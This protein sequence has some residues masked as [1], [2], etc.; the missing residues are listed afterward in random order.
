MTALRG[1]ALFIAI[2]LIAGYRTIAQPLQGASTHAAAL[3]TLSA[4]LRGE[5]SSV[6]R[7]KC[8][9]PAIAEGRRRRAEL[10]EAAN[11]ALAVLNARPSL[12][13]SIVRG[14]F[15]IHFDLTGTN[16]P[17]LLDASGNAIP[18]TAAAFAESTASILSHAYDV[19]VTQMGYDPPPT[20]GSLGGGP[21]YDIYITDLGSY[22]Y[23]DFDD[24]FNSGG[25]STT[26]MVIDN[27]FN[28]VSPSSN[29]GLPALRVTLAHEFHHMIQV[30]RYAFWFDDQ[31]FYE[32][33]ST[34]MED[35][36]YGGVN[37]Y[38]NYMKSASGHFYR[39][40]VP[41]TES[42]GILMYSRCILAMF[43]TKQY[44]AD[45]MRM[46]WDDVRNEPPL[47]ALRHVLPASFNTAFTDAFGLW[48]AWNAYTGSRTDT[49]LY[50]PEGA[51][52]P[53]IKETMYE[54]PAGG[55]RAVSASVGS[56]G[57]CYYRFNSGTKS[58]FLGI[59]YAGN[60]GGDDGSTAIPLAFTVSNVQVDNSYKT[61]ASGLYVSYPSLGAGSWS[62][63][64]LSSLV[65]ARP[66]SA[67]GALSQG[68]VFPNPFIVGV[69]G[70][71]HVLASEQTALLSIYSQD[72][73]RVYEANQKAGTFFGKRAF[74]W[75]GRGDDGNPVASGV[76]LYVITAG[77]SKTVGKFSVVRK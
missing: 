4:A 14:R 72:M 64:D 63:W 22:G 59:S 26:F 55:S 40:E 18:G 3:T 23:T 42:N 68:S 20:D 45:A 66:E 12:S 57:G 46:V 39:P 32:L 35:R 50:Y 38:Y 11:E 28:W 54:I 5:D 30:G 29:R 9:F 17:F 41:L 56:P 16:E 52:Y 36:V 48:N 61:T 76:Y 31:W 58:L 51:A 71:V 7:L 2:V 70:Q 77:D 25:T 62:V 74:S 34:W 44:G 19:E 75:D 27:T 47:P 8:A 37:D 67:E 33:T 6:T 21:E 24:V 15:A 73:V 13:T 60:G 1:F 53:L 43:L 49:A 69:H 65:P 10:G